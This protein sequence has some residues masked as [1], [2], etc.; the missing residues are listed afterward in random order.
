MRENHERYF[1]SNTELVHLF[2][3]VVV[4][5]DVESQQQSLINFVVIC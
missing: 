1:Y 3:V 2:V 4:V 5:C